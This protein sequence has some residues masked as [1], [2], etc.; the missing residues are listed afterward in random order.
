MPPLLGDCPLA[1]WNHRDTTEVMV[2][3]VVAN[4]TVCATLK[5]FPTDDSMFS[6]AQEGVIVRCTGAVD[7]M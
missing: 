6:E 3:V 1:T 7:G 5:I 2:V 4:Q